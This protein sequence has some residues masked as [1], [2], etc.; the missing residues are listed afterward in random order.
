M[1]EV[2]FNKNIRKLTN[3]PHTCEDCG[4]A[5]SIILVPKFSAWQIHYY[6]EPCRE[7]KE[8][9]EVIKARA[10]FKPTRFITYNDRLPS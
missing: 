7:A 4:G 8:S 3:E 9:K 1:D 6:C 5:L 10:G 2:L